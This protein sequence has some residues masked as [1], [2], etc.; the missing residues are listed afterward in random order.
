MG[1]I[2]K[3]K[4]LICKKILNSAS[5]T[6]YSKQETLDKYLSYTMN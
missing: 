5:E 1:T 2:M 3:F 6:M 4:C